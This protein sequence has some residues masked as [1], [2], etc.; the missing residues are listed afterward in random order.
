MVCQLQQTGSRKQPLVQQTQAFGNPKNIPIAHSLLDHSHF[1]MV[2]TDGGT[3]KSF[4]SSA[5]I[6][7]CAKAGDAINNMNVIVI[8]IIRFLIIASFRSLLI[9]AIQFRP[10]T[11]DRR[12][13]SRTESFCLFC[14]L[15]T[16]SSYRQAGGN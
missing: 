14:R 13:T 7:S 16:N 6:S 5:Q 4:M 9:F 15:L 8:G 1:L 12:N 10:R 3:K 2:C 11:A